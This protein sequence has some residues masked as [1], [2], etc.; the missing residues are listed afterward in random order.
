MSGLTLEAL[1]P[2][3][4]RILGYLDQRGPTHRSR[5]LIDLAS[6]DSKW[7]GKHLSG[8]SSN[9]AAPMI[10]ANWCRRLEKAGL[11]KHVRSEDQHWSY[12]HH[13]IT[14]KGRTLLR[15]KP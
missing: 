3:E 14:P 10:M 8:R 15:G 6:P 11:V 5:V 9:N 12:R 13:A 1:T 2:H 7:G 4:R